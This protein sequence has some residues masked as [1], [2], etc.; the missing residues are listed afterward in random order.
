MHKFREAMAPFLLRGPQKKTSVSVCVGLRLI[1]EEKKRA[2]EPR[3]TGQ[4]RRWTK[5]KLKEKKGAS[6]ISF[7]HFPDPLDGSTWMI[8]VTH[9]RSIVGFEI[10]IKYLSDGIGEKFHWAGFRLKA[11]ALA[12]NLKGTKFPVFKPPTAVGPLFS[13]SCFSPFGPLDK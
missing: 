3:F 2:G 1:S 13:N 11:K 6:R 12:S 10:L 4:A 7:R 8:I 9:R 5:Y